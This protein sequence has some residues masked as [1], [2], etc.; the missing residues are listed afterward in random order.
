MNR[1][2]LAAA[3]PDEPL[4]AS[5]EEAARVACLRGAAVAGAELADLAIRL[6]PVDLVAARVRRLLEA[7]RLHL[8]AFDPEGARDLLEQAIND[9]F[10]GASPAASSVN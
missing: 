8:A 7:G 5:L 6:T 3:G 9:E 2:A 1:S 4:A 10:L